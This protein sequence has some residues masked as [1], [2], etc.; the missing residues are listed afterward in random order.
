MPQLQA[1][2]NPWHQEEEKKT[3]LRMK[4]KQTN[5]PDHEIMV[6]T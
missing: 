3:Q 1:T 4:G 5:E 2:A 6:I